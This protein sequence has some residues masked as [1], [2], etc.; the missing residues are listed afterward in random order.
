[1]IDVDDFIDDF[2]QHKSE[3][4][5]VKA[6]EYYLRTRKLKGRDGAS[7]DKIAGAYERGT[8]A[9]AQNRLNADLKK[10]PSKVNRK[11][12]I[13]EAEQKLIRA[14]SLASRIKDPTIRADRLADIAKMQKKLTAVKSRFGAAGK[15]A[16]KPKKRRLMEDEVPMKSPSG[17][18]LVDFDGPSASARYA[19]GSVFD[20]D[21]WKKPKKP[22]QN[23]SRA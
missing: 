11:R 20:A 3:Y 5:P 7:K 12:R 1:V 22:S 2:L 21:G 10:T 9:D 15:V 4:D 19:D 18:K 16:A 23:R 8:V 17:S 14:K 13:G 6:R